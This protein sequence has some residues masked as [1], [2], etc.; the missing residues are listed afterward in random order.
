MLSAAALKASRP[1][2]GIRVS[3]AA[4]SV[5]G[6]GPGGCILPNYPLPPN[7]TLSAPFTSL[8]L[9]DLPS[10]SDGA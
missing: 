10:P 5:E 6:D 1:E 9:R 7:Q 3:P 4:V 2:A 8:R